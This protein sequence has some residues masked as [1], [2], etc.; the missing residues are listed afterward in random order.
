ME[1]TLKIEFNDSDSFTV[2]YITNDIFETEDEYK[3]LFK[4]LNEQLEK[5]YDYSFHGF[6]DVTIYCYK[7]VYVL[8]FDY[9]DDYGRR[10]FNVTIFL[11][12]EMLYEFDDSE[13]ISGKKIYYNSKFYTEIENMINDIR[14]FEYGNIIYG[15]DVAE[16]LN[17]GIL[18]I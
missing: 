15:K 13:L 14:L 12:N 18:V 2:F 1:G 9:L 5:R 8:D 3:I 16:I 10:D 7:E 4:Y 6:Y 11:N 17:K